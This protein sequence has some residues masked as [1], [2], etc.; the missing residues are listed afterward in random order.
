MKSQSSMGQKRRSTP[1]SSQRELG[2]GFAL[3]LGIKGKNKQ[4][5]NKTPMLRGPPQKLRENPTQAL[6]EYKFLS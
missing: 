6:V 4:P 2:E 3:A 5:P 1:D